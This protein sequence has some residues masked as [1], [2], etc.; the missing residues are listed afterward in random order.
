MMMKKIFYILIIL[1]LIGGS[2]W[3]Y[4]KYQAAQDTIQSLQTTINQSPEQINHT[5]VAKAGKHIELPD[6][7][8]TV[9]TVKDVTTLAAKQNF[10]DNAHDGDYLI[11]YAQAKK[12]LIYRESEDKLINV[13]PLTFSNTD[14]PANPNADQPNPNAQ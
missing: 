8:P 14:A 6:E 7:T 5:I 11:I 12:A 4:L 1:G 13:G 2:W 10:F 3:C 9:A